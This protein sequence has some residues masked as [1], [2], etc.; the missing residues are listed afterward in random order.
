MPIQTG[1]IQQAKL[2]QPTLGAQAIVALF[3]HPSDTKMG[4]ASSPLIRVP[5]RM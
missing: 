2:W 4:A 5:C 1:A 3:I